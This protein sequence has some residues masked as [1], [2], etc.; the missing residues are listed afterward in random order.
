MGD[1]KFTRRG[2]LSASISGLAATSVLGLAPRLALAQEASEAANSEGNII[3]RTLGRTG[4]KIPIVSMGVM[5]ADNPEIVHA[6]YEIGIRHFDTAANYQYGRNEQMVGD[7]IKRLGARDKVVIATKEL[8]PAQRGAMTLKQIKEK[9]TD[10]CEGSLN[11]LKTDYIDILYIHTVGSADE[12]NNQDIMEAIALLKKQGKI[13][14]AG[15][16]THEAMAEVI[17]A[18][19]EKGFYD[20]VLTAVNVAMADDVD[21]LGAIEN[22]ASRGVGVIAMK[23][24][25]GGPRLPNP[26][27]LRRFNSSTIA[28]ACLKWVMRNENIATAIPGYTNFEHMREDF[29]V[30]RNLEYTSEEREFLSDNSITLSM[31]FCRQCRQCVPTCPKGADV[32]TLMRTHMYAA[33]YANF[34]QARVVLD[35]IPKSAGIQACGSCVKC[36]ARCAHAVDI[37]R[38]IGELKMMYA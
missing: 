27:T 28:T 15:I 14:F 5:N 29:S 24:Q 8:R 25:A 20:V 34:H 4:L 11:R 2:F 19:A 31:G 16:A 1:S 33:Q 3:Y 32:P 30:A 36:I 38:K 12:A 9:L 13:R 35:D 37:H 18:V 7:V 26:E 21:L 23:T 17:N 10:L 6:S 22:A